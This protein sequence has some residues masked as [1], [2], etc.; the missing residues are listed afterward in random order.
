MKHFVISAT[1]DAKNEFLFSLSK[2]M[3]LMKT[4][5]QQII[6]KLP[7]MEKKTFESSRPASVILHESFVGGG[8]VILIFH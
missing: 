2:H 3:S 8:E 4:P 6:R 7:D 5:E 1:I